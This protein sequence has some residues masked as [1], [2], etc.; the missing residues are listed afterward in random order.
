MARNQLVG[1]PKVGS[2][3]RGD[4]VLRCAAVELTVRSE[5]GPYQALG[6]T[7]DAKRICTEGHEGRKEIGREH[8]RAKVRSRVGYFSSR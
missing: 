4:R 5:I 3:L 7:R 2:H 8:G 6:G 1:T